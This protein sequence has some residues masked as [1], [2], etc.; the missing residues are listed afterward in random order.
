MK[1][2]KRSTPPVLSKKAVFPSPDKEG[3]KKLMNA[4]E[5]L[6]ARHMRDKATR[7]EVRKVA[8]HVNAPRQSKRPSERSK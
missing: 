2:P 8:P 5:D 1:K 4:R 7:E 6:P 3:D